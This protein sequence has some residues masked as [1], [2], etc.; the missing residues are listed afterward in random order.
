[1]KS[2][3]TVILLAVMAFYALA[4]PGVA[5]EKKY[6]I[7]TLPKLDGIAWSHRMREGVDQYAKETGHDLWLLGPSKSDA[8][9][10]VQIVES[11][12]AQGV[13]A[14]CYVPFSVEASEPALKKAREADI[15]IIGHEATTLENV[16]VIIEPFDNH[17]YGANVMKHLAANMGGKGKYI[18]TVGSL[19]SKS[20]NEWIDGAVAYQEANFP[21][22]S[23][24][25]PRLETYDD[26]ATDY[27]KLKEALVAFPDL[28]GIC[29]A[30]DPTSV[31]AGLAIEERGLEGK[32]FFSGTGLP[33]TAGQYI[34]S[35]AIQT[36]HF[37]DPKIAAIAMNKLAIMILDGKRDDIKAGL[38]LGIDGFTDLKQDPNKPNLF[39]G[40][41]WVD[42]DKSNV[43][44]YPF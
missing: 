3:M 11:L 35:G 25:A 38:N 15:V 19:T 17:A 23:Q 22:M 20:H 18:C 34:K 32:V 5:G 26:A 42:V 2:R 33:S 28:K 16:D 29:G 36:I 44:E 4:A 24:A 30:P 21:E 9:E 14:I 6:K 8:A 13:D 31:G 27:A 7:A 10:Q 43:D 39:Y 37:W 1:M 40:Q 41:G 12:I